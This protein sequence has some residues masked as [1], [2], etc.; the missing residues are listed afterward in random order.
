MA[1]ATIHWPSANAA[2]TCIASHLVWLPFTLRLCRY[3]VAGISNFDNQNNN[4]AQL[5]YCWCMLSVVCLQVFCT[6]VN[7]RLLRNS[8][9]VHPH[10]N[11]CFG[12]RDRVLP[13]AA[14]DKRESPH[15]QCSDIRCAWNIDSCQVPCPGCRM[16][17]ARANY[18]KSR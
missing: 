8:S 17:I 5:Q 2:A 12:L 14:T 4:C 3:L 15:M 10:L 9:T 11:V 6:A 16:P 13:T 18:L 7:N 1:G